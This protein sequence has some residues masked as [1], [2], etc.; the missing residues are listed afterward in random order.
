MAT[1]PGASVGDRQPQVAVRQRLGDQRAGHRGALLG[2][3]AELLGHAEDRQPDL[4]AGLEHVLGGG[5][6]LVG[7]GGGRAHHLG[8]ELGDHVDEH[9]LVLGR[10]QVED[11]ARPGARGTPAPACPRWPARANARP[12]VAAV[13]KPAAG[14]RED[15]LLGLPA[16]PEPVEEVALGEPVQRGDGVARS[17][18][19]VSL[20]GEAVPAAGRRLLSVERTCG[21][22]NSELHIAATA[23][24]WCSRSQPGASHP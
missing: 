15:R 17:G 6:G 1:A 23:A 14:D 20:A 16:Q 7:V 4:E 12:A 21:K 9:L 8:G 2:D 5:A 10:G 18:R 24:P 13:R 11:A 22:C 3:A 19:G